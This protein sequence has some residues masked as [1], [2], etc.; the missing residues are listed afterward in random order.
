MKKVLFLVLPLLILT[1]CNND[2]AFAAFGGGGL[3]GGGGGQKSNGGKGDATHQQDNLKSISASKATQLAEEIDARLTSIPVTRARVETYEEDNLT[4]LTNVVE[5]DD[6][7]YTSY[8]WSLSDGEDG[9]FTFIEGNSAYYFYEESNL[10]YYRPE[11]SKWYVI[12][13]IIDSYINSDFTSRYSFLTSSAKALANTKIDS[14]FNDE[15]ASSSVTTKYY[16]SGAGSLRVETSFGG[17][18]FINEYRDYK[19]Y[20]ISSV[21]KF[22]YDFTATKPKDRSAYTE[23]GHYENY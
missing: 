20:I 11:I 12:Y 1:G 16:S 6:S 23:Y 14:E 19:P 4:T 7:T 10:D 13:D 22:S 5:F 2:M 17:I 9:E 15:K 18:K 21:Y 8:S 3:N